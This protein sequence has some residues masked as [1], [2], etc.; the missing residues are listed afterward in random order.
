MQYPLLNILVESI[1][2]R[3]IL[4]NYAA[5]YKVWESLRE[6]TIDTHLL[7]L[8]SNFNDIQNSTES[9]VKDQE[10]VIW[11]PCLRQRKLSGNLS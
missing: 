9:M 4:P 11:S 1:F 10:V 8:M 7:N 3:V 6:D 2:P 5:L